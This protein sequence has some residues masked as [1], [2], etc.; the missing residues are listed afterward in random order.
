[1]ADELSR[2]SD[3]WLSLYLLHCLTIVKRQP[4]RL[5]KVKPEVKS[6]SVRSWNWCLIRWPRMLRVIQGHCDSVQ[7]VANVST[8]IQIVW[9][10]RLR[11]FSRLPFVFEFYS[12]SGT[13]CKINCVYSRVN[14]RDVRSLDKVSIWL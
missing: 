7:T 2:S 5:I 11:N 12:L 10:D 8:P 1:M 3:I 13:C 6:P 9:K 14:L 4:E